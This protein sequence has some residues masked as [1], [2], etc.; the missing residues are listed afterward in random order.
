MNFLWK[1]CFSVSALRKFITKVRLIKP[2]KLFRLE[3][4]QNMYFQN[5]YTLLK[6]RCEM[7]LFEESKLHKIGQLAIKKSIEGRKKIMLKNIHYLR[8]YILKSKSMIKYKR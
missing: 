7:I 8:I 5:Y 1:I 4:P 6:E 2:P 3:V